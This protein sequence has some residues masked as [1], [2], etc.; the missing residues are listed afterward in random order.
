MPTPNPN[1]DSLLSTTL[2]KYRRKLEDNVFTARPLVN[3]LKS[4]D[5]LRLIDGG[6]KIV[7]QL[8][9]AMNSTF[10]TYSGY[11]TLDITP[12]EGISAAEF[13]WRQAAVSVAISGLEEAVNSGEAALI[14]LLEARVMQAEET[15][16]ERFNQMFY[17]DGTGNGGKDWLGLAAIVDD[18]LAVGGIDPTVA[19]N[20]FWKSV[21]ITKTGAGAALVRTDADWARAYNTASRGNDAPDFAVT[22]Q[23]LF[24]HY[25]A[26]LAPA[27]R[28]TDNKSADARFQ[29][30]LFKSI[31]LFY[32]VYCQAGTTYFLNS[33]YLKL[34]GHKN[35]WFKNTP[36]KTAVDKDAKWSQI[37]SYGNLTTSNRS[38]HA[39]VEAQTVA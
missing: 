15:A 31:P 6:T 4:R 23:D 19:G 7:E 8:M 30:L 35:V 25:E 14:D 37:L 22:T 24:E 12:Q 34:V 20:E 5:R 18:T 33:K 17:L 11:D 27:L 9:Y 16:A 39:K 28:F 3:W 32:D 38:R 1:F 2:A 29:N 10:D 13:P 36:F 21:V 26:S